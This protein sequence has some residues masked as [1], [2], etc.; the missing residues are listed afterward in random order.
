MINMKDCG[1]LSDIILIMVNVEKL[2]WH[3]STLSG[4]AMKVEKKFPMSYEWLSRCDE[5]KNSP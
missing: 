3:F 2:G 1:G 4:G 5:K